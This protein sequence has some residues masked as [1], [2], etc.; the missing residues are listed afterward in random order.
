MTRSFSLNRSGI[1][2]NAHKMRIRNDGADRR[3]L[4]DIKDIPLFWKRMSV[5]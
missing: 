1:V 4:R 2:K 5:L 3:S